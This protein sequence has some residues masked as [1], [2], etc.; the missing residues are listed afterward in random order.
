MC[1]FFS[2]IQPFLFSSL[3]I[4]FVQR[5]RK[6]DPELE[7]RHIQDVARKLGCDIV[8]YGLQKTKGNL[9]TASDYHARTLRLIVDYLLD[10]YR[11][12]FTDLVKK[13]KTTKLKTICGSL[14]V[15][16]GGMFMDR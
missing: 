1:V 12:D 3:C 15:C 6:M 2:R 11:L 10:R 9:P 8:N 7:L 16:A 13:M 14:V 5:R 4:H